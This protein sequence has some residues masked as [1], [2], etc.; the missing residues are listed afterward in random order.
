MHSQWRAAK[1]RPMFGTQSLWAGRNLYRATPAVI[2]GL[3]FLVPSFS[4]L[5]RLTRWCGESILSWIIT[6]YDW[7]IICRFTPRITGEKLQNLAYARCSVPLSRVGSLSCHTSCDTGPRF[8]RSHPKDR[9][10]QLSLTTHK[11][12]WRIYSTPDPHGSLTGMYITV[13]I[14]IHAST[15]PGEILLSSPNSQSEFAER[16][17]AITSCV[18]VWRSV[19]ICVLLRDFSEVALIW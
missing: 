5:L 3:G 19:K 6:V 14:I 2:R 18:A 11:G 17:S 4:R 9:P 8:F 1:F 16:L 7:L 10:I 12:M 15:S 13:C